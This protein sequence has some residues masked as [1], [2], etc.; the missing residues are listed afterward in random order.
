MMSRAGS[1]LG[2]LDRDLRTIGLREPGLVLQ[3]LR[4]QA[5]A[6]L[7]GIAEFVEIE[8]F[9]RQRFA[10]GVSLALLLI[11]VQSQSWGF[12][13][14]TKLPLLPPLCERLVRRGDWRCFALRSVETARCSCLLLNYR[15]GYNIVVNTNLDDQVWRQI[16]NQK[17][18]LPFGTSR[19][20]CRPSRP[21]AR[22]PQSPF[23]KPPPRCCA[24][25]PSTDH[26]SR[27]CASVWA[28][29]L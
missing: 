5:V 19:A 12:R 24:P 22:K 2:H 11:D 21:P 15:H 7:V 26:R 13:H 23:W 20:I 8:Q 6:V 10:A 1:F 25:A 9:G 18:G 29:P 27:H 4:D 28:S 17:T 3:T 14:S 16:H